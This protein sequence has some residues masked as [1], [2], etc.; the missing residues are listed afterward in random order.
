MDRSIGWALALAATLGLGLGA[1]APASA[2]PVHLPGRKAKA[3]A[4]ANEGAW[5][6]HAGAAQD[7]YANLA[8]TSRSLQASVCTR[9]PGL[10]APR[11]ELLVV[12]RAPIDVQGCTSLYLLL[13]PGERLSIVNPNPADVSGSYKLD[14]LAQLK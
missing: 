7:I 5:L 4:P 11:V 13:G 1:C 10:A 2:F 6:V 9:G 3:V 12:G 14:L 8:K